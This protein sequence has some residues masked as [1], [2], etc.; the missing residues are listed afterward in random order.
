M[1]I[2]ITGS[3]GFV[4][5]NLS[6]N[7]SK[8]GYKCYGIGRAKS[9]KEKYKSKNYIK[10]INGT[11]NDNRLN[12]FNNV[13]FEY[14]VHCAGGTSPNTNLIKSISQDKDYEKN[15]TSIYTVLNYF[16]KFKKKPKIIFIST[17]SV[18]GNVKKKKINENDKLNP[19]SNY[20]F[21]K[22]IAEKICKLFNENDNFD[23]LILRGSSLYGPGLQ[24]QIIFDA[25]QKISNGKSIFFGTG[26]ETRD[27]IHI[28]DFTEL[29]MSIIKKGFK[30]YHIINAGSGNGTKIIAVVRS[31]IKILKKKI[32]PK[33]NNYG[34]NINPN[35][36][37]ADIEK[38]KKFN[39]SP[40]ISFHD[41][42]KDYIKWF[43]ND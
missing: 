23:I 25:C 17:I 5:K 12:E 38:S 19:I 32:K 27:F 3:Q 22:A 34:K 29:I 42:L 41:G 7:L 30:G 43:K 26:K 10:N 8:F 21:N 37:I 31:V 20:A 24:R 33:F 4:G 28:N 2:L 15:V 9:K 1:N 16:S 6:K 13:K 35:S 11:I 40:K 18:C 14:I 39:W 36:L